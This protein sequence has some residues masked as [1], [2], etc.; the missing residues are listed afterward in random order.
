MTPASSSRRSQL[1]IG[2]ALAAFP[3]LVQLPFNLLVATFEYP[4]ILRRPAGEVLVRF[5]AGGD[6]LTWIW[7]AYALCVVPFLI[8]VIAL[9]GAL[10]ISP[11]RRTMIR[12]LGVI[13][14]TTQ[15][16]GLLRW[17]LVVPA[18]SAAYAEPAASQATRDAISVAFDVQHRLFGNLLGEH[19]GQLT[20][21]L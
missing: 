8:T 20:L 9:P 13:S 21:A 6:R 16:I 1:A 3:L 18:L 14:A 19:V 5:A 2:L 4:D 11:G 15:L 17:T 12:T 7:Y 10:Q